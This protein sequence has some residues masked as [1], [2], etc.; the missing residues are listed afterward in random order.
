MSIAAD[1]AAL[2]DSLGPAVR[3]PS[4]ISATTVEILVASLRD[5]ERRVAVLEAQPVPVRHG[6][7]VVPIP[8]RRSDGRGEV[9]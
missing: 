9:A 2:A 7:N 8:L 1:L 5:I 4:R 6:G 3:Q